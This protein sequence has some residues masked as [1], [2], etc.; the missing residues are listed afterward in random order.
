MQLYKN[1]QISQEYLLIHQFF[2]F[3]KKNFQLKKMSTYDTMKIIV[4][5]QFHQGQK[6]CHFF[7]AKQW[8]YMLAYIFSCK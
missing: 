4:T 1:D 5:V 2:A 8:I 7:S 6:I 3:C